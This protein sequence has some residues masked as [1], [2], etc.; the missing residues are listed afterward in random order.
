MPP[1]LR[2]W[3]EKDPRAAVEAVFELPS[4]VFLKPIAE[5]WGARDPRAALDFAF[6]KGGDRGFQFAETAFKKWSQDDFPAASQWLS[7]LPEQQANFLTPVLVETWSKSDPVAAMDWSQQSLAGKLRN[8]SIERIVL[9][10]A[11]SGLAS[12]KDLLAQIESRDAYQQAVVG[13]S[14]QLWGKSW[15]LKDPKFKE[16]VTWFDEVEDPP[17]FDKIFSEFANFLSRYDFEK[18]QNLVESEK[19]QNVSPQ[20]F[21]HAMG[22]YYYNGTPA[23][24]MDLIS[25]SK[26]SLISAAT[27]NVFGKWYEDEPEAAVTWAE[28]LSP[29]DARLPYLVKELRSNFY[30]KPH[31]QAVDYINSQPKIIKTMLRKELVTG[32]KAHPRAF[33]SDGKQIDWAQL[34]AETAGEE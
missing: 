34:L 16:A 25:E 17:T 8:D 11:L 33:G 18:F 23:G 28:R 32:M 6:Q 3:A 7:G 19:A 4:S 9:A 30:Y 20:N 2:E 24:A 5:L 1:L 15:D 26:S 29:D 21:S 14:H 22:L 31:T 13:L 10:S 12:P 27:A